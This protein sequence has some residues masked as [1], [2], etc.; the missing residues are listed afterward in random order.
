MQILYV[1]HLFVCWLVG[2]LVCLVN[3]SMFLVG[4]LVVGQWVG[5]LICLLVGWLVVFFVGW[6]V[7]WFFGWSVVGQWV[8]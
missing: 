7:C 2:R 8:G 3:G 5:W 1:L 4:R 6:N